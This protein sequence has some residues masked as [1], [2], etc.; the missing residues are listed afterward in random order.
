MRVRDSN[1]RPARILLVALA[2]ASVTAAGARETSVS[3]PLPPGFRVENSELEGPVFA[4]PGGRT[5][6]IWP[7][8]KLRNG[9]SGE[10]KGKPACYDEVRKETAGLMSPYPAGLMLPDAGARPSCTQLWP[11]VIAAADAKPIGKWTVLA[12]KDGRK[13]WA[14]DE[15]PLYTSSLD[16]EPG[17][18][19]GGTTRKDPYE[20]PANRSPVGP[21]PLVPPG[22][23]VKTTSTGRL[24]TT[25]KSASVYTY[26]KDTAQQ[27]LCDVACTREWTPLLAPQTALAKGEWST[28]ERSPGVHQWTYRDKPLYAHMLDTHLW[29]LEGS[30]VPGW[31][32]VYTQTAS[33][34]AHFT[35]QDTPMGQVL[36]DARGRTIYTYACGDD[37]VDQLSCDGPDD[38][39]VYRLAVCGGGDIARCEQN[40]PYVR[41][42]KEAGSSSRAWTIIQIDPATGRRAAQGLSAWSVWAYRGR[43]VFTYAKDVQPGDVHGDGTGEWRGFRNGLK[44]FWLRDDYYEGAL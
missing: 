17:E 23:A 21:P 4:D 29:S 30:D 7:S 10:M 14:Y 6:Y 12:R 11:P 44:A 41:A 20:A 31:H 36:A 40:W 5:L 13:Q 34:P 25:A 9:Y 39:Q 26:D 33:H 28:I 42:D 19:L 8:K 2:A 43:P 3:V 18:A 16:H 37:S 22:F 27:S 15:Q 38:T 24:L 35:V 1:T 32:N